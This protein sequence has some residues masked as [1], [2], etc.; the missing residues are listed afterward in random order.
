MDY[1]SAYDQLGAAYDPQIQQL[2]TQVA[3]LA[4]QQA[5]QQASLD[6]AKVNA[7][8]DITNTANAKGVLFSGVPIDQQATYT[9]TKYL[10]AVANLQTSFNN[11]KNLLQ[12]QINALNSDRVKTAQGNVAAY[13]KNQADAQ[14]KQA[15]LDLAAQ[16]NAISA[17]RGGGGGLTANQLLA[18]QNKYQMGYKPNDQG[19]AFVGPNGAISAYEYA[20]GKAQGDPTGTY[21]TFV[22]ALSK[23]PDSYDKNA[24]MA[25]KGYAIQGLD[26]GT[27][28]QQLQKQYGALF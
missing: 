6:Q 20:A 2:N 15:Q 1:Q 3:Q 10:P 27:A 28:L 24:L 19:L 7:F 9:G 26:Q 25:L 17:A 21:N 18:Q 5:S 16:R 23:S 13:I 12:S 8:K 22:Q 11:S 4:P 14:Y